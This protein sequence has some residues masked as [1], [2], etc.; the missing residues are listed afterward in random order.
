MASRW[1]PGGITS[2]IQKFCCIF[3]DAKCPIV[4]MLEP[5]VKNCRFLLLAFDWLHDIQLLY[6]SET[7]LLYI[8]EAFGL[9]QHG[10]MIP[11]RVFPHNL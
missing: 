10:M 2:S 5:R 3:R 11:C 1:T 9:N 8:S 7:Q 6:I 4:H